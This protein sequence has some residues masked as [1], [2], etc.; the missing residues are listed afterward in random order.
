MIVLLITRFHGHDPACD[1]GNDVV[2][3]ELSREIVMK[4]ILS[5]YPTLP[6]VADRRN[7]KMKTFQTS[8]PYFSSSEKSYIVLQ[9][10]TV[11]LSMNWSKPL[12]DYIDYE[13]LH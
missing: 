8:K 4:H 2:L 9:S 10:V 7:I 5:I 6:G 12:A 1:D 11:P 13:D 3:P